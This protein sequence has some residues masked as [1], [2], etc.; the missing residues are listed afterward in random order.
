MSTV[1]NKT[2]ILRKQWITIKNGEELF[3]L[4]NT[5]FPQLVAIED[6]LKLYGQLLRI[7]WAAISTPMVFDVV[8]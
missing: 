1:I 6:E 7:R 4:S 5:S 2:N 3:N 8:L